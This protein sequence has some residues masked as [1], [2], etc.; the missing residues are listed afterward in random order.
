VRP[1]Q[2]TVIKPQSSRAVTRYASGHRRA[3]KRR[4]VHFPI[5]DYSDVKPKVDCWRKDWETGDESS[6]VSC[7]VKCSVVQM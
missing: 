5:P 7:T 3:G 4:I 2:A 1:V 6:E